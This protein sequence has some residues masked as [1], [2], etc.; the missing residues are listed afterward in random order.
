MH[1]LAIPIIGPHGAAIA[2]AIPSLLFG[3]SLPL[4]LN[5]MLGYAGARSA[6]VV[7][8]KQREFRPNCDEQPDAAELK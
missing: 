5:A 8:R 4:A 1:L 3:D 2:V 7:H 6:I